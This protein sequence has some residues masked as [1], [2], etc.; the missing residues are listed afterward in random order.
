MSFHRRDA[1]QRW[2]ESRPRAPARS[3]AHISSHAAR[4]TSPL[5]SEK[6]PNLAR[7][8][9]REVQHLCAHL[10]TE[11]RQIVNVVLVDFLRHAL[12]AFWPILLG[13]ID[14][15]PPVAAPGCGELPDHN[16]ATAL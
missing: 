8:P 7:H 10:V 15:A 12:Q 2:R 16:F 9:A 13:I 1:R 6:D 5:P 11:R 4:L 3:D 14:A